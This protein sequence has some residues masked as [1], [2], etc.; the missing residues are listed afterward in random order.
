MKVLVFILAFFCI[1][2][3]TAMGFE[4]DIPNTKI[5]KLD[6]EMR[7][8]SLDHIKFQIN[9]L[10]F[11]LIQGQLDTISIRFLGEPE[12]NVSK[13][14]L[15]CYVATNNESSE[16][17]IFN[18]Y[19]SNYEISDKNEINIDLPF[20]PQAS[21]YNYYNCLFTV[22]ANLWGNINKDKRHATLPISLDS[23]EQ[24]MH[25]KFVIFLNNSFEFDDIP[26]K[27]TK[28][29]SEPKWRRI[30]FLPHENRT[31][32]VSNKKTIYIVKEENPPI[33]EPTI[34]WKQKL[35]DFIK[36]PGIATGI[37]ISISL[38]LILVYKIRYRK[39]FRESGKELF[40]HYIPIKK[41]NK[42]PVN[43]NN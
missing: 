8:V 12:I 5:N 11:S 39:S 29:D 1:F 10:D 24:I 27:F 26:Q 20:T 9:K 40:E 35:W 31:Q 25:S 23:K 16:H 15:G 7:V 30:A 2:S 13:V 4:L 22:E 42:K 21:T 36:W 33:E 6:A 34:G 43:K 17:Q 37:I 41:P 38:F 18:D 28:Q 3:G 32:Y 14:H 19:L